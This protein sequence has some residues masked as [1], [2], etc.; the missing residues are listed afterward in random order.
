MEVK[1]GDVFITKLDPVV[2]VEIRKNRPA[3][4]VQNDPANVEFP[5][6]IVVPLTSIVPRI[7]PPDWVLI[8]T[9]E[10][11]IKKDSTAI[12]HQIRSVDKSRLL[13]SIGHL[14][15]TSMKKIDEAIKI[16]LGLIEL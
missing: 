2:G 5:T 8:R 15:E 12:T 1:R 10:G 7:I 14:S 11:G 4:I 3:V 13:K 6:T 9:P 16:A